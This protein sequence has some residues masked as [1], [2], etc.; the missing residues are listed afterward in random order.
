MKTG[1]SPETQN[2]QI[3]GENGGKPVKV[4]SSKFQV[5]KVWNAKITALAVEGT[6]IS[7]P[8]RKQ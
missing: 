8:L 5:P 6:I 1:Q 4:S 2:L 3:P 7:A